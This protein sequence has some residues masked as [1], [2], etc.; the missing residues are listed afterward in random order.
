MKI[1]SK[2]DAVRVLQGHQA[3]MNEA[4]TKPEE[5]LELKVNVDDEYDLKL[6]SRA[7][8]DLGWTPSPI[9][10]APIDFSMRLGVKLPLGDRLIFI[11]QPHGR[12]QD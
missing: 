10:L 9:V 4:R 7:A 8:T 11:H 5:T 6:L 1:S 2:E 3:I 12:E